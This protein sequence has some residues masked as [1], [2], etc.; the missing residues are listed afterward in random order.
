M[1]REVRQLEFERSD[2][3]EAIWRRVIAD[4]QG[5]YFPTEI[6][7][8]RGVAWRKAI[9]CAAAVSLNLPGELLCSI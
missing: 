7:E 4:R 8:Q 9:G 1:G 5:T 3:D 6:N 2:G